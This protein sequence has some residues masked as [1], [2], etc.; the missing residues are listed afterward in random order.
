MKNN[1]EIYITV[2]PI[3]LQLI[4]S[5]P[6][7]SYEAPS[8]QWLDGIRRTYRVENYGFKGPVINY[9]EVGITEQERGTNQGL[10]LQKGMCN[11]LTHP[12]EG[13][14]KGFE[15]V[16]QQGAKVLAIMEGR[17]QKHDNS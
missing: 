16:L 12:E 3:L 1:Q 15:V 6:V 14:T 9:G 11:D 10:P 2:F 13:G 4:V 8:T 5:V 7:D 17:V